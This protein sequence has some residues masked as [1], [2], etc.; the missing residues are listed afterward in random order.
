MD[1][2]IFKTLG[3]YMELYFFLASG[4]KQKDEVNKYITDI[5]STSSAKSYLSK[6]SEGELL[7]ISMEGEKISLD[8]N[9]MVEF[10]NEL[11]SNLHYDVSLESKQP[12]ATRKKKKQP[13]DDYKAVTDSHSPQLI[14]W[15]NEANSNKSRVNNLENELAKCEEIIAELQGLVNAKIDD[16]LLKFM[17]E[18]ILVLNDVKAKPETHFQRDFFLDDPYTLLDV[19]DLAKKNAQEMDSPYEPVFSTEK[20]LTTEKYVEHIWNRLPITRI[21]QRRYEEQERLPVVNQPEPEDGWVKRESINREE[22]E[23]NRLKSVNAILAM[24]NEVTNQMKLALYAAWFDGSDPEMVELL[25]YAGEHDIN[26]NYV[27]HLL[28][29]PKEYRNYRT[30]RG[31]LHHASK[32]SEAHIKREAAVE[33]I[34]GDWYMEASYKGKPCQFRMMPVTELQEFMELLKKQQSGEALDLLERLLK[35][36][37][38]ASF[39]EKNPDGV[40]VVKTSEEASETDMQIEPPSF[41]HAKEAECGVDCHPKINDDEAYDGFSESEE[42]GEKDGKK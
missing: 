17:G 13:E 37:R 28:E 29:K 23:K 33:L 12:E 3:T 10:I 25:N 6:I 22:I 7:Y 21:F 35:E 38:E 2:K 20:E 16:V 8:M 27:I 4:P 26:A 14:K 39:Q 30:I 31:L 9:A 15:M 1:K 34:T 24:G 41:L 11:A 19:E 42:K 40:V 32:A 5:K 36:K 18:K